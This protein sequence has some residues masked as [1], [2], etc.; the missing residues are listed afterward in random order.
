[1]KSFENSKEVPIIE[2]VDYRVVPRA[3][4]TEPDLASVGLTEVEAREAGHEVE[5]ST[6]LFANNGRAK[7]ISSAEGIVK[8][9]A[10]AETGVLLG[11]HI[12]GP[13]ADDLIHEVVIAM[14]KNG[15]FEALAKSIHVHPT[16]PEAIKNAAKGLR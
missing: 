7:A 5:T 1:M 2:K 13:H 15:A 14:Y 12:L 4:F 16:L 10:D 3:V 8:L 11:G 6:S 9:V